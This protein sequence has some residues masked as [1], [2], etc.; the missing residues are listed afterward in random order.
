MVSGARIY[1]RKTLETLSVD[2]KEFIAVQNVFNNAETVQ[3]NSKHRVE[4]FNF[5]RYAGICVD[6]IRR[7]EL[8]GYI[9]YLVDVC[10]SGK[11][12]SAT[13]CHNAGRNHQCEKNVY[14]KISRKTGIVQRC[15][16]WSQ[17]TK[18]PVH[19]QKFSS[20]P[21]K[22]PDAANSILFDD[23]LF[24]QKA[25]MKQE[26]DLMIGLG[27]SAS[28][29]DKHRKDVE[30]RFQLIEVSRDE[31]KLLQKYAKAT[32]AAVV[33]DDAA[34]CIDVANE[35]TTASTS[36]C[37]TS[38]LDPRE[39][40]RAMHYEQLRE[41][42]N[43]TVINMCEVEQNADDDGKDDVGDAAKLAPG[44][45]SAC[46][47]LKNLSVGEVQRVN[48]ILNRA[49]SLGGKRGA[50]SSPSSNVSADPAEQYAR[51]KRAK[52]A[53][54]TLE[55]KKENPTLIADQRHRIQTLQMLYPQ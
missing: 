55:D 47:K 43:V 14:F 38:P 39:L 50:E 52:L 6:R 26:T 18:R 25:K 2:S 32:G 45:P 28:A 46:T 23:S 20:V 51:Y 30:R 17:K 40:A 44:S 3:T 31:E 36:S 29:I 12:D 1:A 11:T 10:D 21:C 5:A 16:C 41:S 27:L 33:A 53:G 15:C 49:S 54:K 9:Y 42:D 7:G 13:F 8:N 19:C 48:D 37:A 35:S 24:Q 34:K 22:L 4:Q